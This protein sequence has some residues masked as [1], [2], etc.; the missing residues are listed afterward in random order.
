MINVGIIGATGY[1]GKE[2]IKI[3]SKHPK[4]KIS[5]LTAKIDDTSLISDIFPVFKGVLDMKCK[6][7]DLDNKEL[8]DVNVVFLA[9]PHGA[10]LESVNYFLDKGK[11]VIDLSA[12]YRLKDPQEYEAW[13]DVKHT[14]K[15]LL[16]EAVYGLPEF[17]KE[18]IKK[19]NLI[20]NPGCFPTGIL[21]S[22]LPVLS[23]DLVLLDKEIIIDSKTGTSGAGRKASIALSFS[24]LDQ[25][26]KPYKVNKHQHSIEIMRQLEAFSKKEINMVFVPHL[27][28]IKRGIINTIYVHL[29]E[30]TD[31]GKIKD[32]YIKTYK[33]SKFVKIMDSAEDISLLNVVDT[34]K[35][36]IGINIDQ[37]SDMLIIA[38]AIDN[39]IKG[40]AG[41]AVQNMNIMYGF[42]ESLGL[43]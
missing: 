23:Q 8:N 32:L 12:D 35:C 1:T 40:A 42:D 27:V 13:Y 10:A 30:K 16:K 39:L 14:H 33:D 26:I 31:L 36:H 29:K 41:Q 25:D 17:N 43:I 2:L 18:A 11:K 9:V 7:F 38:S 15:E 28:S 3:L 4:V 24:E 22:L 19:A 34:N 6:P 37:D 21:L 20:A 5:S